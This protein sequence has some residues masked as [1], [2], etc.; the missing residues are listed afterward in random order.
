MQNTL[1]AREWMCSVRSPV[2]GN[3]FVRS[4]AGELYL[5]SSKDNTEYDR[6]WDLQNPHHPRAHTGVPA[7]TVPHRCLALAIKRNL[8]GPESKTSQHTHSSASKALVK[9]DF[10][11]GKLSPDSS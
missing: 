4:Q 6:D 1:G 7:T 5:W 2:G 3:T 9:G 11:E 10:C 8:H